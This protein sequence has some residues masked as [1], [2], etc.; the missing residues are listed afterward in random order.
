MNSA[1]SHTFLFVNHWGLFKVFNF[2]QCVLTSGTW[3]TGNN[4]WCVNTAGMAV[5]KAIS[6][7]H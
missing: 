3:I 1:T 6:T 4:Y 2:N 7:Q 5:K